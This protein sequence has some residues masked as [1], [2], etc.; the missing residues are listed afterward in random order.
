MGI[1]SAGY[2]AG[3]IVRKPGPIIEL[4]TITQV[5]P[6]AGGNPGILKIDVK[7]QN[8]SESAVVKDRSR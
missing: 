5:T 1:S 2:L 4:I 8:L 6:P 7:G 3:K